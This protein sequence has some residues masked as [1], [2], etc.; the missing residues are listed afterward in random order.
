MQNIIITMA[1]AHIKRI[2]RVGARRIKTMVNKAVTEACDKARA[3]G[4]IP[5]S[6]V[7]DLSV[8]SIDGKWMNVFSR[9]LYRVAAREGISIVGGEMAQM[10]DTY[11]KG[12][13]GIVVSVV[14]IKL[15]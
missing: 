6:A 5:L 8:H 2:D 4:A 13:I 15:G 12:Y 11:S 14:S 10:P 9:S 3:K 1:S 7:D